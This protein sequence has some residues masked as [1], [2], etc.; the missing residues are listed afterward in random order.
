MNAQKILSHVNARLKVTASDA[1]SDAVADLNKAG[2]YGI[3][4]TSIQFQSRKGV[5]FPYSPKQLPLYVDSLEDKGYVVQKS[6]ERLLELSKPGASL[7]IIFQST[8]NF[9]RPWIVRVA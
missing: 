3:R 9:N 2:P 1:V 6:N 5:P 8:D 4:G 7:K